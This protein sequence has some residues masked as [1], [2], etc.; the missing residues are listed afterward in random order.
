MKFLDLISETQAHLRSFV[1]DQEISTHLTEDMD[2]VT[3]VA[4]VNDATLVSRG[5]IEIDNELIW[6]DRP[7]RDN[8]TA[9]I[10]PY[11]RGM[12][13][14]DAEPHTAGTRVIIAPL[15]PR[16]FLK[17]TINQTIKQI[18]A[19]LY[20]V[21]QLETVTYTD[22]E[23]KYELP[24]YTRD[25]L[26]VK[27]TDPNWVDD[28][29]FLRDWA[30]DKNAPLSVSST[31]KSVYLYDNWV[32]TGINLTI[33]ISRDPAPLVDDDDDFSATFLP[34]SASDLPVLGAA[35]RL[36]STSDSYDLQTRSVESSTIN[37]ATRGSTPAQDQSKYL[38]A[39]FMQRMEEERLRLLNT[40]N[41]RARYQDSTMYPRANAWWTL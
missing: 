16:R 5:R 31:G 7:D 19:S 1:R 41:N 38:Q 37:M 10:P 14:T 30:F 23:F 26:N 6:V 18:G 9:I 21:E 8:N 12:D 25:V 24:A 33:T 13:G 3:T 20:G 32:G 15:Y 11:G 36:L 34:E 2:D 39:L 29:T 17:D 22:G 40:T 35:A 4:S 27:V 28:V